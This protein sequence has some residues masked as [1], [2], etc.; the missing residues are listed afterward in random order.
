[1]NINHFKEKIVPQQRNQ[2]LYNRRTN[3]PIA[4]SAKTQTAD[5]FHMLVN[6]QIL[7]MSKSAF[8][9]LAAFYSEGIKIYPE[10]MWIQTPKWCIE[11]DNWYTIHTIESKYEREIL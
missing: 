11:H 4:I 7:I 8:S 5:A 6:A 3:T 10:G 1:M 2:H 9:Y